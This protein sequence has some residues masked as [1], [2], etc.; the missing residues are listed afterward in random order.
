MNRLV[1]TVCEA[2]TFN[3]IILSVWLYYHALCLLRFFFQ[4]N[5]WYF[6]L[7]FLKKYKYSVNCHIILL[8]FELVISSFACIPNHFISH[9][10]FFFKLFS[11]AFQIYP[12]LSISLYANVSMCVL[13][14]YCVVSM[15]LCLFLLFSD[16]KKT[17]KTTTRININK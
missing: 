11:A 4:D 5:D 6:P 17:N 1:P 3:R 10:F 15:F 9:V 2:H 8:T 16:K 12:N 13:H 14:K 7:K